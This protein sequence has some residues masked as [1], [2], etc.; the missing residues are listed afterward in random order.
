M[1]AI[2]GAAAGGRQA[3][4][5]NPA[6]SGPNLPSEQIDRVQAEQGSHALVQGGEDDRSDR[7]HQ[8][9]DHR[10]E[11]EDRLA[12]QEHARRESDSNGAEKDDKECSEQ[13]E[14]TRDLVRGQGNAERAAQ[15]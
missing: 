3:I 6:L 15:I 14:T 9:G 13:H 10:V 1:A 7:G 4:N 2:I 8:R 5:A 11:A 12:A